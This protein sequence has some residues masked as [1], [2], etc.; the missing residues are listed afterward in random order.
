[1]KGHEMAEAKVPQ[2]TLEQMTVDELKALAYDQ[3][4]LLQQTQNNINLLQAEINK[5]K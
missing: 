5:R 2:K 4:V 3:L 1:V